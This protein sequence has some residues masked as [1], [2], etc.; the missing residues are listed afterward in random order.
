M[1]LRIGLR[2]L[3]NYVKRT[4]LNCFRF[5]GHDD[6]MVGLFFGGIKNK[7]VFLIFFSNAMNNR[8]RTG[9]DKGNPTV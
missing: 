8:L 1:A 2:G 6:L 5:H 4:T 3:Y 7:Y 9:A